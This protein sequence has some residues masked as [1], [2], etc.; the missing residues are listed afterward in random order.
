[1]IETHRLEYDE[2]ELREYLD[3][4]VRPHMTPDISNYAKGRLRVWIGTE[5]SLSKH[6]KPKP[7]LQ[8]PKMAQAFADRINW[9]FDY[10]LVTYSGDVNPIGISPHRDASYADY[11]AYGWN[12]VGESKFLYWNDRQSFGKSASS[13]MAPHSGPPTHEINLAP[14]TVVRF[15]CKNL[16]AAIPLPRRW[17]VNFWRAKPD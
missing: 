15:N 1:M 12:L 10:C 8:L 2:E 11:E 17:G 3:R 7:G 13:G 6:G 14:G 5:P 16:H 9:P 4:T